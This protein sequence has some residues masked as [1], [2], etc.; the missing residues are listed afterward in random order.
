[1]LTSRLPRVAFDSSQSAPS[2][3][4]QVGVQTACG[5]TWRA[6]ASL[7]PPRSVKIATP[8]VDQCTQTVG[9]YYPSGTE[10]QR[11]EQYRALQLLRKQ[12]QSDR[13]PPLTAIS[14]GRGKTQLTVSVSGAGLQRRRSVCD[15]C[16]VQVTGGS[17]WITYA[18]T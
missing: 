13:H 1:M 7:H 12:V 5:A 14:P 2:F 11:K 16:H 15:T 6:T 8:T 9:L 4:V 3:C 10:L 17:S 18:L